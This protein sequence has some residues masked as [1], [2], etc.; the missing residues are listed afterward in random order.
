V[1]L[2][3][4][5]K[6]NLKK[7]IISVRCFKGIFKCLKSHFDVKKLVKPNNISNFYTFSYARAHRTNI[8]K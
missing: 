4:Y 8:Q 7:P 1:N 6:M 5:L 3:S 2:I